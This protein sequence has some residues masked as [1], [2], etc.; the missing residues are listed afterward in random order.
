MNNLVAQLGLPRR[1]WYAGHPGQ[2]VADLNNV[3]THAGVT[4]ATMASN[5]DTDR[6]W[7]ADLSLGSS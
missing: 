5:D 4:S 6:Y 1:P 2:P 3:T 7:H